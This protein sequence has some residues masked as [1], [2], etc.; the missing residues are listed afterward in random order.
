[1]YIEKRKLTGDFV[2]RTRQIA[3]G[4]LIATFLG[5]LFIYWKFQVVDFARYAQLAEQNITKIIDT[6]APR[7]L[8]LDRHQLILSENKF[9]FTLFLI[10]ENVRDLERT[11]RL[12]AFISGK[13]QAQ[14]DRLL[15]KYNGYPAFFAIPIRTNIPLSTVSFIRSREDELPE[16]A[17]GTEPLRTYPQQR[18]AAHAIGYIAEI[19]EEELRQQG[20]QSYKQGDEIG[21]S[22][23]ERQY[24]TFLRGT[25][26]KQ[27]AIKNNLE[28]IQRLVREDFPEIGHTVMTTLDLELQRFCEEQLASEGGAIGVVDLRSGDLL[29]MVSKPD[30]NPEAF[31]AAIDAGEW[32]ELVRNPEKPLQNKLLQGCYSP[33][34]AFKIVMALAA[35]QEQIIT[36]ATLAYCSGSLTVYGRP[37]NC[38]KPGGH[39][40]V[41]LAEALR[42]SCN[43]YFY[44]LGKRL[45][46][47]TIS[48]Y[49]AM[50]GLGLKTGID[51]PN[52]KEGL[53]PALEW[54]RLGTKPKWY[55][56]ETISLAIGQGSLNAT[57]L[58]ML[59]MISTVAL[60]G[61]APR[62][63]VL[64][65][66]TR[67]SRMIREFP[68]E[69]H[70]IPIDRAH[71]EAVI[72]GL[73]RVVN[74]G[75]TGRA[76]MVSGLD[77]CG[78]TGTAQVIAKDNPRY[79][80]LIQEKRFH[81]HSW[82]I[83]FAPRNDPQIAIVVLIENGGD[84]GAIAAPL[85]RRIYQRYFKK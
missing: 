85:A 29:A 35:L 36:P 58:Q 26:G 11:R 51:L 46:V 23:I 82:F 79:E 27:V 10:R 68:P 8:I 3:H 9:N 1:M 55:A 74:D 4:L 12:A 28:K 48:R 54:L 42:D 53:V 20:Y 52:E 60:R 64:R 18:L 75:G 45:D 2:R 71:F 25:K 39:G 41:D 22:G 80:R 40:S 43:V 83:S 13:S 49:A 47:E 73:F 24:E 77:I 76:A 44:Q 78:K 37:F 65:S 32:D 66:I 81:P 33:G 62:L 6:K 61:R 31:P 63:H 16:F 17:I 19:T 57:P 84:A 14:I 72:E 59:E 56:G 5:L 30:F 69:F 50:L 15:A 70:P 21:R 38:W 34:S 67:G 7:G